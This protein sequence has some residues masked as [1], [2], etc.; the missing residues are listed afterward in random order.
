MKIKNIASPETHVRKVKA[1]QP[2]GFICRLEAL[3]AVG[4]A[5]ASETISQTAII[6]QATV[7]FAIKDIEN[8]PFNDVNVGS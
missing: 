4:M 6:T 2:R 3:I 1:P 8:P 7:L 5:N